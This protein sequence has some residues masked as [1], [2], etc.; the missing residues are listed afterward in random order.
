MTNEIAAE[1]GPLL[2][3][4]HI[5][6]FEYDV[7]GFLVSAH[8]SCLGGADPEIEVRAGL[9]SP[10]VVRRA[11]TGERV[12]DRARIG[13]RSITV[14]HEPVRD[15]NGR[16]ERILATAVDVTQPSAAAEPSA[17]WL[18]LLPAS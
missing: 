5:L 18:A 17:R 10:A 14:I 11:A 3:Q 16:I 13:A 4:A 1:L 7:D 12:V 9:V 15:E 8:G 6:M 2:A